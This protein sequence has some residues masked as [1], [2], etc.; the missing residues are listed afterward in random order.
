M[1]PLVSVIVP[2]WNGAA[3]LDAALQSVWRQGVADLQLIVVDDGSTDDTADLIASYGTAVTPIYQ[4]NKGPAAARNVGLQLATGKFVAFL[5]T[6]DV[7][8]D[9]R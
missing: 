3:Y 4:P 7:W 8:V 9:G 1:K 2:V 6:D 5:D